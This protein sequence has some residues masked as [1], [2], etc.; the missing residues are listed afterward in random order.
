[1]N[2]S[3]F[4][5]SLFL[6]QAFC[7][8]IAR[9]SAK[10]L[11]SQDDYFLAG[12]SLRFFSLLMTFLA[13]QVGGG[14]I[15]GAA[16][17]A[18]QAGW[19]VLLLPLGS[20]LGL[21]ALGLGLGRR[22]AQFPVGTTAQLFDVVYD[23]KRLKKV[24]SV[25]SMVSLFMILV[26]QVI[27]SRRFVLS[28]GVTSNLWFFLFWGMVIVYTATGG[29]RAVVATDVI[30]A[31]FFGVVFIGCSVYTICT[32]DNSLTEVWSMGLKS[33]LSVWQPSK[34]IAW[35]LMPLLFMVIEQD[36]A[37]R[38]LA[39]ASPRCVSKATIWAGVLTM[40]ICALPVFF[41]VL[42]KGTDVLAPT[43][44]SVF[45][46]IVQKVT[47]PALAALV[48]CAVIAAIISTAD[49]LINAI[50]ANLS[51]DF[52][53]RSS[54]RNSQLITAS[55]AIAAIVMSFYF[56][57]VVGVLIQSYEL[58]VS[59]LFA[60][61][62]LALFYKRGN[63][64]SAWLAVCVGAASFVALRLFPV[65][66]YREVMSVVLSFGGYGLGELLCWNA[67][68]DPQKVLEKTM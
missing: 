15:L 63:T 59:C 22:L 13:T 9:K 54:L 27:A 44:S 40:G 64:L 48:G 24:A 58:S 46:A 39:A 35:L 4:L 16:E 33:D 23:S 32:M 14:L 7:M 60:P 68:K 65:E 55:I 57:S 67:A 26:A 66:G 5:V 62:F 61:I 36:M 29:L 47:T 10:E 18:Y 2:V 41:G 20:A 12:R 45:M 43:G 51:Q 49:S 31:L 25:L 11:V 52:Q 50:G 6:L 30:Q 37:Q 17:E 3:L 34:L 56:T 8:L 1:M 38:C 28:L 21:I 53:L 19:V 42:A